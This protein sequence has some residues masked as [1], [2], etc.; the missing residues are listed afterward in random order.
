VQ[1]LSSTFSGADEDKS[2]HRFTPISRLAAGGG[3]AKSDC[4]V[5]IYGVEVV[6]NTAA[7]V[8]G[9]A[10]DADGA[11]ND[12]C[13]FPI[14]LCFNVADPDLS[15]CSDAEDVTE[16]T[17]SAKPASAAVSALAASLGGAL[18]IAGTT[19]RFSDGYALPVKQTPAGRKDGKATLKV[20]ARTGDGRTD[21]DT[22]KLVCTPAP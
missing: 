20:K 19:C 3:A 17:V 22:V 7:C 4:A 1:I 10:C 16:L 2:L 12:S 11:V 6:G 14:G 8:D 18:P 21:S 13:L 9:A 5:E 15:D